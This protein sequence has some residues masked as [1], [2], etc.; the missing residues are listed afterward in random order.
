M[1][2]SAVK[3]Q[4]KPRRTGRTLPDRIYG[5][6]GAVRA[7]PP[8]VIL[9]IDVGGEAGGRRRDDEQSTVSPVGERGVAG[10]RGHD[11]ADAS[12]A[13]RGQPLC[14]VAWGCAAPRRSIHR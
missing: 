5:L 14:A 4:G 6:R 9:Q 7:V 8:K 13:D 3:S 10:E 2:T 11:E 12:E 1:I